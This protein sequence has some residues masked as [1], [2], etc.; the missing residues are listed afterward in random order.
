MN[1]FLYRLYR[2]S[3][4]VLCIYIGYIELL[5]CICIVLTCNTPPP[6]GIFHA[7]LQARDCKKLVLSYLTVPNGSTFDGNHC[8][9]GVGL[10]CRSVGRLRIGYDLSSSLS[11]LALSFLLGGMKDWMEESGAHSSTVSLPGIFG[12]LSLCPRTPG[13]PS[14]LCN[15]NF[16]SN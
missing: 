16:S 7:E 2:F 8:P 11:H 4:E 13:I 14:K 5:T 10:V 12:H 1:R 15:P 6:L 9:V 3:I